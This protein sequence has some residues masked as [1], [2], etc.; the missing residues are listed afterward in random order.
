MRKTDN[1]SAVN[2]RLTE[3]ESSGLA[4]LATLNGVSK[5]DYI[6]NLVATDIDSHKAAIEAY[7]KNVESIRAELKR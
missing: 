1:K 5:T 7:R 3:E 6:R 4:I 2:F